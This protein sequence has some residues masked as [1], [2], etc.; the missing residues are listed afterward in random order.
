MSLKVI[1][2]NNYIKPNEHVFVAGMTQ[3]GK[4]FLTQT[5]LANYTQQIYVLDTKGAFNWNQVPD[6]EKEI[7]TNLSQITS[8]TKKKVIYR[9]VWEELTQEFYNSFFEF[10]M[11]RRNCIIVIDEVM[12]VCPSAI[13]IPEWY[14]GALTRGMELQVGVWSLSQRPSSIPIVVM[15]EATHYFIFKLNSV[16]DRKRIVQYTGH[17]E[18]LQIMEKK[19]FLYFNTA[20]GE[21][22]QKCRLVLIRG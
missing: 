5:Y 4:T 22:P 21:R 7:I 3:S 15:T 8:T 10:C 6:S 19:D 20:T 12:Q 1:E 2:Q 16:D 18:F 11:K 14:K 17:Q 9:P 13:K